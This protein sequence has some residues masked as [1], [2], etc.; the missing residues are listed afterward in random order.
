MTGDLIRG[1]LKRRQAAQKGN[2]CDD[3]CR[4][5]GESSISQGKPKIA[6]KPPKT[7]RA[8]ESPSKPSEGINSAATLVS[9]FQLQYGETI[10]SCCLSFL[11]CSTLLWLP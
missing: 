4:D 5:R 1:D 2:V 6:R 11:V 3:E 10:H 8:A 7:R 9:D